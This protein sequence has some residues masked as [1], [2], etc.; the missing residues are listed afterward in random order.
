VSFDMLLIQSPIVPVR[1]LHP[2]SLQNSTPAHVER[3]VA[4]VERR[5]PPPSARIR[6]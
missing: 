4:H 3:R 2:K 1:P 6:S 5:V